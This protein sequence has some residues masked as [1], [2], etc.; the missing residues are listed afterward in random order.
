VADLKEE[1]DSLLWVS[2]DIS[3]D[4]EGYAKKYDVKVVPTIVVDNNGKIDRHSG[5]NMIGYYR[6]L[7]L[8]QKQ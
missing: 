8:T 1:F 2:V 4:K 6:I 7:R 5:T 3:N